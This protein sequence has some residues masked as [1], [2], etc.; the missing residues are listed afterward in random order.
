MPAVVPITWAVIRSPGAPLKVYR[1]TRFWSSTVPA[2]ML[3]LVRLLPPWAAVLPDVMSSAIEMSIRPA[4]GVQRF[5]WV[6]ISHTT[7][8]KLGLDL[9]IEQKRPA[10]P[11]RASLSKIRSPYV[12]LPARLPMLLTGCSQPD[13]PLTP[14]CQAAAFRVYDVRLAF[15]LFTVNWNVPLVPL[16]VSLRPATTT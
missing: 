5:T 11:Y 14:M 15:S 16:S 8:D 6:V 1:A 12:K 4:N 3:P 10:L 7:T 13:D 9:I 2:T